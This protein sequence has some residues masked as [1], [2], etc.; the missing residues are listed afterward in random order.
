MILIVGWMSVVFGFSSEDGVQSQSLSDKIT[1]QVIEIIKPD[2]ES[3]SEADRQQFFNQVSFAVR[4]TGH[5]CEYGVLGFFVA[6]LLIT[7]RTAIK[8]HKIVIV[9]SAVW[10]MVYAVTD[11]I[12]QGF[13]A[14]RSP[15][16]MDVAIDTAGGIIGAFALVIIQILIFKIRNRGKKVECLGE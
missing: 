4:K 6:G 11:E 14:G 12:H 1:T 2:F 3:L 5:F 7:F 9:G 10:C 13:V 8:S 15:K 16:V